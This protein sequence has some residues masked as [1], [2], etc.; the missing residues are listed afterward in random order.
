MTSIIGIQSRI[1][2]KGIA[3]RL[4]EGVKG[5]NISYDGTVMSCTGDP[6]ELIEKLVER[7]E[8]IERGVAITLA[9][10]AI[11]PIIKEN[12]ELKIPDRLR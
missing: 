6:A 11:E 10:K 1:I 4:A 7:Y 8:K 5:L 2:G 9:K 3:V 12:P